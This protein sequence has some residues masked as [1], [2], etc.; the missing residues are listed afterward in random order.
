[1]DRL[2]NEAR[3]LGLKDKETMHSLR[4]AFAQDQLVRYE[5]HGFSKEEALALVSCDLGHGDGR[6]RYVEQV[7]IK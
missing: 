3:A 6:G 1:M 4:Y 5:S 2:H 7:Y